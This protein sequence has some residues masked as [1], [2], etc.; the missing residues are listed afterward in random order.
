MCYTIGRPD[1]VKLITAIYNK[2]KEGLFIMR[3]VCIICG[4]TYDE[5]LGDEEHGI[6]PGTL[7]DDLPD[8][9]SCPECGVG[10]DE[11]ENDLA[12]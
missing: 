11:F 5:E 9:F 10:K 12:E 4:Y 7:W 8:D 1:S 6:E 2:Q 3:Y